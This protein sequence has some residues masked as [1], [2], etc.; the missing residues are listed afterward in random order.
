MRHFKCVRWEGIF[1]TVGKVYSLKDGVLHDNQNHSTAIKPWM[2]PLFKEVFL[3][4]DYLK[5]VEKQ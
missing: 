1:F 4:D 2:L 5:E 3:F